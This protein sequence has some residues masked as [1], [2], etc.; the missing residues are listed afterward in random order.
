MTP[1]LT[2]LRPEGVARRLLRGLDRGAAV[3]GLKL[4]RPALISLLFHSIF[5]GPDE[6]GLDLV[7]PQEG[8]TTEALRSCLEQ[9]LAAGYEFV[10]VGDIEAGLETG[11]R[12]A[13][14]TFDDG[15]ANNLR[16][17]PILEEY[18][19]PAAVFVASGH[20]ERAKRFWW[21]VIWVERRRRGV[22]PATI[23][24]EIA[25]V[26]AG[27]SDL[28]ASLEREF[29]AGSSDPSSDLDRPLTPGELAQ[30]AHH[31]LLTVGNHTVNHALL[32]TLDEEAVR[33]EL[34]GAQ[35]YIAGVTGL[36]PSAVA[37]PNGDVNR[38]VAAIAGTLGLTVGFTT[39]PRKEAL[40]VSSVQLLRLGR[41]QIRETIGLRMEVTA[42]RSGIQ[43]L[44]SVR[45]A[46]AWLAQ[47]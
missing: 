22:S 36:R 28:D 46:R 23:E 15:Y 14:L 30:L 1:S 11:R 33:D 45:R 12:Y 6:L 37:Y 40:P 34:V 4:E 20:V 29:G 39:T 41:F 10:G 31:P 5:D 18:G 25:V 42:V 16:A 2:A 19:V 32:T 38:E 35:E 27:V 7:H 17:V 47:R 43:P 44:N 8:L 24:R 21:D 9:F 3:A 26:K 13:C